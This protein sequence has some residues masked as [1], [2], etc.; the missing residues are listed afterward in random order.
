M[1]NDDRK[2]GMG[3]RGYGLSVDDR[4]SGILFETAVLL[5]F[6]VRVPE[7]NVTIKC[8]EEEC[9]CISG[10]TLGDRCLVC[11]APWN[12]PEEQRM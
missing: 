8:F 3:F 11:F 5:R 12:Q 1:M 6:L 10:S 2:R 9:G 7:C 4:K